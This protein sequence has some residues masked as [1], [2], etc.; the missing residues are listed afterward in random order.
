MKEM[1]QKNLQ[2]AELQD[3]DLEKVAGGS[4]ME[5]HAYNNKDV[6]TSVGIECNWTVNPFKKDE[7]KY[8][9]RKISSATAS[10]LVF[11]SHAK[12]LTGDVSDISAALDYKVSHGHGY[13]EDKE[14]TNR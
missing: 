3:E 2:A 12:G 14:N 8:A 9:G 5:R 10:A 4:Y 1:E 7:F 6:Y 13:E 11:Y